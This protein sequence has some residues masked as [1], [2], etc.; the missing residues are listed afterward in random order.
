MRDAAERAF[1]SG[2][3]LRLQQTNSARR[4]AVVSYEEAVRLFE[5]SGE[6]RRE[7]DARSMLAGVHV[8]LGEFQHALRL[9]PTALERYRA[10]DDHDGEVVTLRRIGNVHTKLGA[11][12][13]GIDYLLEALA[14]SRTHHLRSREANCLVTLASLHQDDGDF[15]QS[16]KY[17][18]AALEVARSQGDRVNEADVMRRVGRVRSLLGD[19]QGALAELD[20]ARQLVRGIG[21]PIREARLLEDVARVYEAMGDHVQSFRHMEAS[22]RLMRRRG[23][24]ES[25]MLSLESLAFMYERTGD[26]ERALSHLREAQAAAP[27]RHLGRAALMH[28][29]AARLERQQGHLEA[30]RVEIEAAL[31][32]IESQHANI[33]VDELRASH[34]AQRSPFY[35]LHADVLMQLHARDPGAGHDREAL[36]AV[37]RSRARTLLELLNEAQVVIHENVD[38]ALLERERTVRELLN[39]AAERQMRE[40]SRRPPTAD[41]ELIEKE[42]EDLRA[43]HQNLRNRIKL[44]SPEYS[45]LTQ[46]EPV[47]VT[48]MQTELLDPDTLLLEY[49]LGAERSYLWTVSRSGL[50]TFVLPSR[51]QI[52]AAARRFH[53]LLAARGGNWLDG[54]ASDADEKD[55]LGAAARLS[56]LVVRPAAALLARHRLVIVPDGALHF[57]PFAALPDPEGPS[58]PLI[59]NHELV[60]LPSASVLMALRRESTWRSPPSATAIVFADPVFEREDP[61]LS[62]A[63]A[64]ARPP[65]AAAEPVNLSTTR[66]LERSLASV[67]LGELAIP[68]LPFTRAEAS[69]I[70]AAIPH[71]QSR[72]AVDFDASRAIAASPDLSSYRIVHF[73]T[74][75]LLNTDRPELS[76]LI[77]SLFDREGRRQNG[78]FR[79]TDIFNLRLSADLVVL[80][81]CQT[82]LG[83]E[84][85]GEG[86][87]GL[88]R[89]FM[90]AGAPRVIASLWKVDD[91]ATAELMKR[92][93]EGML[94]SRRLSPA[95][96]LRAAQIALLEQRR[97]KSPY[98]WAGF[99]LHGDWR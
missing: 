8:S 68:R 50:A 59:V 91:R 30:A 28:R 34:A 43:E 47:A 92:T 75:G 2:E 65:Q 12:D 66:A 33:A 17:L 79:L 81:G 14:L 90:Y 46:P 40:A 20:T 83:K 57:I 71:G 76:G 27:E 69:A 22:V 37:E 74:H 61:R 1:A 70:A 4:R 3:N 39:D 31:K 6:T 44:T 42:I 60:S 10:I 55:L 94:G 25:L 26:Y 32:I 7:A 84:L 85:N 72:L 15:Q 67:G 24:P 87:I 82:G 36:R 77:L 23:P 52:E 80:S 13:R 95:A 64:P 49:A 29:A 86:L 98:Y 21:G 54:A 9:F 11:R 58:Q 45:A 16:A 73:A 62:A 41:R 56:D 35:S 38:Q 5:A 18:S 19:H 96:A 88:T 78:F 99:V 53:E 51:A 93:Y 97:W 48:D 89:G 63:V